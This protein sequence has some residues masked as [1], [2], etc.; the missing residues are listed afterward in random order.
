MRGWA[1][2]L[3]DEVD[4]LRASG[5]PPN[6]TWSNV[7][8][9]LAWLSLPPHRA[10]L[11]RTWAGLGLPLQPLQILSNGLARLGLRSVPLLT[12][13]LRARDPRIRPGDYFH[14]SEQEE[15]LRVCGADNAVQ[16]AV[17]RGVAGPPHSA[18]PGD[19]GPNCAICCEPLS[20]DSLEW[21]AGC[22]HRLHEDCMTAL[23][24]HEDPAYCPS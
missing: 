12:G 9:P 17:I 3:H 11:V 14:A 23:L 7:V 4:H 16:E 6:Y 15:L 1:R 20:P 19:S 22:G 10:L 8:V 18:P 5:F 21:P 24:M 13:W 2:T